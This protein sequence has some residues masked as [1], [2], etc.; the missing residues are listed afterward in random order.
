MIDRTAKHQMFE[1]LWVKFVSLEL[2]QADDVY[3]GPEVNLSPHQYPYYGS[4]Y[5]SYYFNPA[6]AAQQVGAQQQV[7]VA[8]QQVATQQVV[9]QQAAAQQA[10]AQQVAAQQAVAQQAAAQQA[11]AQQVVAQQVAAQQVAAQQQQHDDDDPFF[12]PES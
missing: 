9:A 12:A 4:S 3:V 7:A 8:A 10:T 2:S 5:P 1:F 11:T 6:A